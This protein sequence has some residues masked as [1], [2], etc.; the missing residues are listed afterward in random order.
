MMASKNT[1]KHM[2]KIEFKNSFS[3][4]GVSRNLDVHNEQSV[5]WE[6]QC[7]MT[8]GTQFLPKNRYFSGEPKIT[9]THHVKRR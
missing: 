6:R 3:F 2:A 5:N 8:T 7:E 9:I 4:I 1:K